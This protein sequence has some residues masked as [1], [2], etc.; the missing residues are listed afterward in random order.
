MEYKCPFCR[1]SI[2]RDIF[3]S[4]PYYQCETSFDICPNAIYFR[5]NYHTLKICLINIFSDENHYTFQS[6]K[7]E[8]GSLEVETRTSIYNRDYEMIFRSDQFIL[9]DFSSK[10]KLNQQ[11][12]MMLAF[13]N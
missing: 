9:P 8:Y 2:T 11:I 5:L 4:T 7:A 12:E 1:R 10:E 3:D 6:S 13:N